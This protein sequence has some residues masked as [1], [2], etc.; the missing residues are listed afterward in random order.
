MPTGVTIQVVTEVCNG[1]TSLASSTICQNGESLRDA[2][3]HAYIIFSC[4][5]QQIGDKLADD[6][7]N[8]FARSY[9]QKLIKQHDYARVDGQR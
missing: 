8:A 9:D 4:F 7:G 2:Q 3:T 6:H 5:S 1:I